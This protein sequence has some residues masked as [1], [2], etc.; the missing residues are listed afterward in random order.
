MD[1]TTWDR[2][3]LW[4]FRAIPLRVID[5]D[6][7]VAL[8]DNGYSHRH[9]AHI[10]LSGWSAPELRD[11][12]GEDA[13]QKLVMALTTIDIALPW[14]LRIVSKQKQTVVVEQRSLERYVSDVWVVRPDGT[15]DDVVTLL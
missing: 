1:A 7:F 5:G 3:F 10:R 4:R 12:G 11:P 9:E 14:S 13:R 15:M 8:V 6:T 2:G